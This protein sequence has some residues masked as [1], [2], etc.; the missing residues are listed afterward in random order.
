MHSSRMHTACLLTVSCSIPSI[1]G[2]GGLPNPPGCR[3]PPPGCRPPSPWMQTPLNVDSPDRVTC[4]ACW[5]ANHPVNRMT[6][7]CKNMTI[8]QIS[9]AGGNN[10]SGGVVKCSPQNLEFN[11]LGPERRSFAEGSLGYLQGETDMKKLLIPL[12]IPLTRI[13]VLISV[14]GP[15]PILLTALIRTK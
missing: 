15:C 2:G 8:P 1:S 14:A 9:I 13:G 6:H 10:D 3:P 5:E 12:V 11:V 7:R 4:D